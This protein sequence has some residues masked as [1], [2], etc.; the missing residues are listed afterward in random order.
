MSDRLSFDGI[1]EIGCKTVPDLGPGL[2][3]ALY[4][5]TVRALAKEGVGG[6]RTFDAVIAECAREVQPATL[7]TF[8]RRHFDPPPE[9]ISVVEPSSSG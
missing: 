4:V 1:T 5:A 6:G 2:S 9:G 7:L 3:G 8:N